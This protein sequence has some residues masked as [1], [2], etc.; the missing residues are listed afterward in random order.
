VPLPE[1]RL[2][3]A[4]RDE[5]D[6]EVALANHAR[7]GVAFYAPIS[8]HKSTHPPKHRPFTAAVRPA[9]RGCNNLP[10]EKDFEG[11]GRWRT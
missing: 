2:Q 6:V 10:S 8:V 7:S 11:T 3:Q 5:H 9:R 1:L 4:A